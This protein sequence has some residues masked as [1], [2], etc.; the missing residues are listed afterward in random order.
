MTNKTAA[1]IGGGFCGL[2]AAYE[3]AK[4]GIEVTL[5][6]KDN[7]L[8]GL[9]GTF[10]VSPGK[11]LEKF[12][13]HW[14]SSDVDILNFIEEI[15]LG[16]RIKFC[17]SRTG[18]YH[19]NSIFRLASPWDLLRFSPLPLVD[20][21]RTGLMA[22]YCRRIENWQVLEDV[23]AKDWIQKIAGKKSFE[24][25]WGPLLQGKFGA[26][27]EEI[28]AVWFWNKLKLRGS[29]RKGAGE[30][31]LAYFEGGFGALIDAVKI[32][33]SKMG[34]KF[35]LGVEAKVEKGLVVNGASYNQ[36]LVTTS[37]PDF[38]NLATDLPTDYLAKLAQIKFLGNVCLVLKLKRSL[39]SSY[40]LNVAD[41]SFPFVG[42]IE[43]TNIDDKDNYGGSH[44][45]YLSKYVPETDALFKME[46]DP[47]FE[48]A[49]PHLKKIFPD[50]ER[51]WVDSYF[52]WKAKNS[53][54][55]V[56]KHYSKLIP[57]FKTPI[58]GLWLS[59]MAQIYPEDRGTN[60]A[61]KYGRRVAKQ[62]L[63]NY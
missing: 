63:E 40:W 27:W 46:P 26:A 44:I 9:A 36:V 13:H 7:E 62:M 61:I 60:Y 53:Q 47:F 39:S 31:K 45:A 21:I 16:D 4:A 33:L 32:E 18:F 15:G 6:E 5:F 25:V 49:L 10:E 51:S 2:A 29:S 54:P 19:A 8:G 20:R 48:F 59:S 50:L 28:S 17:P 11:R 30:E 43:H 14:F 57:D 52:L 12:Y 23:L 42:I 1:I 41:P 22:L 55:L 56:T 35:V 58:S 34:V 3:L 37:L 24:V 38:T